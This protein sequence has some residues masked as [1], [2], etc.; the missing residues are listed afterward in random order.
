MEIPLPLI[1]E[2]PRWK[3]NKTLYLQVLMPC[4]T[5]LYLVKK[6]STTIEGRI[7]AWNAGSGASTATTRTPALTVKMV[8]SNG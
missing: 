2:I 3:Q 8:I 6:G 1:Q 7:N 4:L 5:A